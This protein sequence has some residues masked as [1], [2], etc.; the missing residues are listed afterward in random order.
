MK[1]YKGFVYSG[2]T[3]V[4]Y[5]NEL[6]R[7]PYQSGFK[8]FGLLKCKPWKDGY[9]LGD[10]RKSGGQIKGMLGNIYSDFEFVELQN[11]PF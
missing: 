3:Y 4:L 10:A 8:F 11:E 1:K 7:L 2:K 6:Y 9:I 5:R